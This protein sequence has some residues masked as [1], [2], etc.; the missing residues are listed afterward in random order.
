MLTSHTPHR[1]PSSSQNSTD[2]MAGITVFGI[3]TGDGD[4]AELL[5]D[6]HKKRI[7]VSIFPSTDAHSSLHV[8]AEE[9]RF[10]DL[11][12]RAVSTRDDDEH[13]E[14]IDDVLAAIL[15]AGRVLFDEIRLSCRSSPAARDL[16]SVLFPEQRWFRLLTLS[17]E[18]SLVPIEPEEAYTCSDSGSES[19]SETDFSID[20]DLPRYPPREILVEE[21]FR[22]GEDT[23][24]RVH[25]G[26]DELLCKASPGGLRRAD[27]KRELDCLRKVRAADLHPRVPRLHGYI[28]HPSRNRPLGFLRDWVRGCSLSDM[29]F[30]SIPESRRQRWGSQI[31]ETVDQLHEIGVAWGDSTGG[32]VIIDTEDD[33]WLIDLGGDRRDGWV[34]EELTDSV[35]GDEQGVRRMMEFLDVE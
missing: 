33:A 27:L 12:S 8:S 25:A 9:D 10:I 13:E 2:K 26:D 14:M 11:L 34:D 21:H 28:V 32:D 22:R 7:S 6:Y 15:E 19:D 18:L 1:H 29:D 23:V 30:P 4:G 17:G 20:D 16:H 3:E 24:C 31:C 5:F 35:A